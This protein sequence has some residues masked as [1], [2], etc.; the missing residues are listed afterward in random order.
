MVGINADQFAENHL[1]SNE[2]LTWKWIQEYPDKLW[3]RVETR[4]CRQ[5]RHRLKFLQYLY[6]HLR[7]KNIYLKFEFTAT[8]EEAMWRPR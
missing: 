2:I 3:N 6:L 5:E 7:K 8:A 4:E 1:E